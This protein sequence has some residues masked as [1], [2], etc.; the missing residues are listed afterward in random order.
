L[1]G[2]RGWIGNRFYFTAQGAGG[3]SK[4][5]H[6][7]PPRTHSIE[8]TNMFLTTRWTVVF[9][10]AVEDSGAGRPALSE[11][12]RK[13]WRPLYFFARHRGLS[14]ADAEDATQAF[15]AGFLDGKL[16]ERADPAK[17]RFRTYMLTAWKRY[18]VDLHRHD[19][20]EKR[21]GTLATLS[22]DAG[23]GE[24][25]WL[26]LSAADTDPDRVFLASWA[27]NLVDETLQRLRS[28]YAASHRTPIINALIPYLTT[29]AT[30]SLY[31]EISNRLG[32]SIGASKVALH[33]LRQRFSQTL[34]AVV[35]ETVDDPEDI[36]T[37]LTELLSVLANVPILPSA[38]KP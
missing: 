25:E 28:E 26:E 22:I 17:G 37:E 31:V 14:A 38:Q 5:N 34:R 4:P 29:P 35:E 9:Q 21:G 27:T 36:E 12:I 30:N 1:N 24:R 13:Y 10:A 18:L 8:K 16:L 6:L 20:R 19:T 3:K 32:T 7:L 15:L 11:I 33:R 23:Q 2:L